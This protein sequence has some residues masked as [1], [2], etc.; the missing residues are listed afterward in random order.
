[1]EKQIII[2]QK[3]NEEEMKNCASMLGEHFKNDYKHDKMVN[4]GYPILEW[5]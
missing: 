1:M 4:N 3:K 5:Q 2:A